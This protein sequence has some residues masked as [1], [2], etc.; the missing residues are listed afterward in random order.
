M[1]NYS[2]QLEY[3]KDDCFIKIVTFV[4]FIF[5]YFSFKKLYLNKVKDNKMNDEICSEKKSSFIEFTQEDEDF[6]TVK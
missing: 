5:I 3:C 2:N 4:L 1:I 6:F